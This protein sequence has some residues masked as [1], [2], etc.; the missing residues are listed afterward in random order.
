MTCKLKKKYIQESLFWCT[1]R[2][3]QR[4]KHWENQE[5]LSEHLKNWGSKK[6][7]KY[8]LHLVYFFIIIIFN[9]SLRNVHDMIRRGSIMVR[10]GCGNFFQ[11]FEWKTI[12]RRIQDPRIIIWTFH[13]SVQPYG[14]SRQFSGRWGAWIRQIAKGLALNFTVF[15]PFRKI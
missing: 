8:L 2:F 15:L 6:E 7:K 5:K 9:S 14:F 3:N 4:I 11:S 10:R 13:A 12:A 1:H